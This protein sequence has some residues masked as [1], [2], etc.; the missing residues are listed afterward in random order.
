MRF[1][2][3]ILLA[4]LGAAWLVSGEL[5]KDAIFSGLLDM[6]KPYFGGFGAEAIVRYGIAAL[7]LLIGIVIA[8]PSRPNFLRRH[9]I[10]VFLERDSGSD[11]IGIHSFPTIDYIQA[12]VITRVP[13]ASCKAWLVKAEYSEDR[14][15]P[16]S[17]EHNERHPLAWSK[18]YTPNSLD[19]AIN[20]SDP[21]IRINIAVF[22]AQAL[23]LDPHVNTP[24]NLFLRLQRIGFHRMTISL[25]AE[26]LIKFA[27]MEYKYSFSEQIVIVINWRGPAQGATVSMA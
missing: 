24:T 9:P 17:I 1:I 5:I 7:I 13:L 12:S 8:W 25:V 26:R 11:R 15:V 22:D 10:K 4:A 14:I 6:L 21:P 18:A 2:G 27:G 16:Y 23:Q 3:T 19:T 20:P